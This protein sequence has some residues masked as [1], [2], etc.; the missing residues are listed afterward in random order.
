MQGGVKMERNLYIATY[1]A[2]ATILEKLAANL[3]AKIKKLYVCY[4]GFKAPKGSYD[5]GNHK[6]LFGGYQPSKNI[7][8]AKVILNDFGE[9]SSIWIWTGNLRKSTNTSQNILLSIPIRGKNKKIVKNKWFGKLP[10]EHLIVYVEKNGVES[11]ETTSKLFRHLE[12]CIN[13]LE[14]EGLSAHV[15][16]PW[17]SSKFLKD[18]SSLKKIKKINV[19]TRNVLNSC[20]VDFKNEKIGNRFIAK[21]L[22][23]FPHMKC[24]FLT[25]DSGEVVWTYIG[26]ANFTKTAMYGNKNVECAAIFKNSAACEQIWDVFRELKAAKL[27]EKRKCGKSGDYDD[28]DQFDE[29]DWTG[30]TLDSTKGFEQRHLIREAEIYFSKDNVQRKLE[31]IYTAYKGGEETFSSCPFKFKITSIDEYYH[32]LVCKKNKK[33]DW[34]E[35]DVERKIKG[36]PPESVLEASA[37]VTQLFNL[38]VFGALEAGKFRG[39]KNPDD[40]DP[41]NG[42]DKNIDKKRTFVN[43]RFPIEKIAKNVKLKKKIIEQAE[44]IKKTDMKNLPESDRKL[45]SNWLPLIECLKKENKK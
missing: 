21:E 8:H 31:K 5:R 2:H 9:N 16:S 14:D 41:P 44:R 29:D 40:D 32:L 4:G 20:W 1:S 3:N 35:V 42:N 12:D 30:S 24:L 27:W 38:V 36:E 34:V 45:L 19:Y 17:G 28:S 7:L 6:K 37:G 43:I 10:E 15:F 33:D 39:P 11:I 22:T 23:P 26:S 18:L 13:A 25:N